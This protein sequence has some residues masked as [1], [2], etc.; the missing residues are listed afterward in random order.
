M[1]RCRLRAAGWVDVVG[2]SLVIPLQLR[3][4]SVLLDTVMRQLQIVPALLA[5]R[6]QGWGHLRSMVLPG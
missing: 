2:D 6:N 4:F 5:H 1:V 3:I